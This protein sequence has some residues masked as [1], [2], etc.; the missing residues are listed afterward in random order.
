MAAR[1]GEADGARFGWLTPVEAEDGV[2]GGEGAA[3]GEA[4]EG[5]FGEGEGGGVVSWEDGLHGSFGWLMFFISQGVMGGW[6]VAVGRRW[7]WAE[8]ASF[9]KVLNNKIREI[10]I[11]LFSIV[12]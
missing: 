11:K 6:R 4:E 2:V 3:G 8:N 10:V 1:E 9:F 7:A 5:S 12:C